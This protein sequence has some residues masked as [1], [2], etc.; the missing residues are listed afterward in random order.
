MSEFSYQNEHINE[1]CE[2][3]PLPEELD[4]IIERIR[5][6]FEFESPSVIKITEEITLLNN[7]KSTPYFPYKLDKFR[8]A[9]QIIDYNGENLLFHSFEPDLPQMSVKFVYFPY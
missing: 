1:I 2:I 8:P 6:F 3:E 5:T 7:G 4:I 9:L